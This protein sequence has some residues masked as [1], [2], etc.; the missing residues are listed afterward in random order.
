MS[1][2]FLNE[3]WYFITVATNKHFPFF[4]YEKE[5]QI[6]VDKIIS[7]TKKLGI[8]KFYFGVMSNHYHLLAYF[9]DGSIIPKLMNLIQGGSSFL[10][11][12]DLGNKDRNTW[13]DYHLNIPKDEA[14][15]DR[16]KGYVIGNPIKH[17]EVKNFDE[18]LN[19]PFSSFGQVVREDG[20]EQA[21][22]IVCSVI[23][24]PEERMAGFFRL[25]RHFGLLKQSVNLFHRL[26]LFPWF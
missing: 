26:F 2:F 14:S 17:G 9:K 8:E 15:F 6:I 11:M 4:F 23:E 1:R 13:G 7:S 18:L 24:T 12:R 25:N 16:I 21:E 22:A 19:Y 5:K 3:T 10:L 20:R